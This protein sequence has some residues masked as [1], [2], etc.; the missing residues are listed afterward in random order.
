MKEEKSKAS[1]LGKGI[2]ELC[3]YISLVFCALRAT[4]VI[5]WNWFWI[6]SPIIISNAFAILILAAAGI[7]LSNKK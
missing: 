7:A 5:E 3:L 1:S 6:L 2:K 4:G